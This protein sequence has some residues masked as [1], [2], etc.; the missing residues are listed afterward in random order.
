MNTNREDSRVGTALR[1]VRYAAARP[2]VIA[3]PSQQAQ[4]VTGYPLPT[5]FPTARLAGLRLAWH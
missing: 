1:A 5:L 3:L 4:F 2:E